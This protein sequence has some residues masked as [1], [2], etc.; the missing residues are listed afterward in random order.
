MAHAKLDLRA[1]TVTL[2]APTDATD[3]TA[4]RMLAVSAT[5]TSPPHG[6]ERL[7]WLLITTEGEP[8]NEQAR[9]VIAWY[10]RRWS[11]ETWFSV[12]KTGTRVEK[13]RLD[14]ADDLRKCLVFDAITA[15]HIHDLNFM[16]RTAPQTPA[17]EVVEQDMIDCLYEYLHILGVLRA[18]APAR[19]PH[20]RRRSCESRRLRPHQTTTPARNLETLG[21]LDALQSS[22]HPL[23]RTETTQAVEMNTEITSKI[24]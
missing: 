24:L 8:S 15:C 1:C 19:H 13:R 16:A 12:L 7:H 5:E 2:A 21:S 18:R 22:S 9:K 4:T 11:I 17:D 6:K 20:L 14:D 3:K 23:S 10:E